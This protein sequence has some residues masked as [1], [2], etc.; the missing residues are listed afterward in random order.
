MEYKFHIKNLCCLA[1][2]FVDINPSI[3]NEAD[4]YKKITHNSF[5]AFFKQKITKKIMGNNEEKILK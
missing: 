2:E 3:I 4:M 5:V 1:Q